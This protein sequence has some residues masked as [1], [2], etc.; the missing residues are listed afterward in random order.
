MGAISF[1][2]TNDTEEVGFYPAVL[3]ANYLRNTNYDVQ[4]VPGTTIGPAGLHGGAAA[5]SALAAAFEL[6]RGHVGG[7]HDS[8]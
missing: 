6:G 5:Q 8:G 3:T 7:G 4:V 1:V 2:R